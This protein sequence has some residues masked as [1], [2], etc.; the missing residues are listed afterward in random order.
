[1]ANATNVRLD[2]RE[3]ILYSKLQK[4]PVIMLVVYDIHSNDMTEIG[5]LI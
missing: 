2:A 4:K 5:G 3:K 1:M